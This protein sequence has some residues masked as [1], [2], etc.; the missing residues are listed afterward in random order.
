MSR[1][2]VLCYDK[3]WPQQGLC[4]RDIIG[5]T[6]PWVR[7]NIRVLGRDRVGQGKEKFYRDII[8]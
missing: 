1:H 2:K 3:E 4:C 8:V 5:T 7:N 6:G